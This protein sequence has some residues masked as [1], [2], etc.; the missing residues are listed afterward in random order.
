M[1]SMKNTL[2]VVLDRLVVAEEKIGER[3]EIVIKIIQNEIQ[4]E[5]RIKTM[6]RALVNY[7]TTLRI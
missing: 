2:R 7:G 5:K 6:N 1:C 3:E 4:T